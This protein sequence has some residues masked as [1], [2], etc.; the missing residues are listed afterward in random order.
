MDLPEEGEP[1]QAV[2]STRSQLLLQTVTGS[3][4]PQAGT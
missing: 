1:L 2:N 4:S 3:Q